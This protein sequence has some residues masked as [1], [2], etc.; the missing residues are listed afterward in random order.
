M[1]GLGHRGLGHA[2]PCV[3]HRLRRYHIFHILPNSLCLLLLLATPLAAADPMIQML[4]PDLPDGVT[5]TRDVLY[6]TVDDEKL[7][8]DVYTPAA[9]AEGIAPAIVYVHGGGWEAGSRTNSFGRKRDTYPLLDA[10]FIVVSID[11]RLAPDHR[12]PANIEDVKSAVRFIRAHADRFHIDPDRIGAMG[13]SAGG[14]LVALLGLADKTAGF[15]VGDHLDQSSRVSAVVDIYGVHDLS[16]LT[17]PGAIQ[18]AKKSFSPDQ[19]EKASP[20]TYITADAPPFLVIHGDK[21]TV[22]EVEQSDLFVKALQAVDAP[23]EYLRVENAQ[24]GFW[25]VKAPI[26]PPM[27]RITAAVVAFFEKTLRPTE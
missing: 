4:N 23:V 2:K 17:S 1:T 5:I 26:D 21:D 3:L 10:G 22:V 20:V 13:E 11:Y 27:P 15:E 9:A 18:A 14:H 8:L 6:R 24:H 7:H 25:E 19:H 16:R 12:F